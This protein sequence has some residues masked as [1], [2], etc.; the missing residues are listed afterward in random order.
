MRK[1][2]NGNNSKRVPANWCTE[3]ANQEVWVCVHTLSESMLYLHLSARQP[4]YNNNHIGNCQI[5]NIPFMSSGCN[6]ESVVK[7]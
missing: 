3:T 4:P 6:S 7:E 5:E 1:G 2:E